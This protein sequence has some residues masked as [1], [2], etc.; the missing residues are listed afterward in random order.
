MKSTG[1]FLTADE[2]ESVK[3]T[4]NTP[5]IAIHT[6][7]PQSPKQRVHAYALAKGLPEIPGYYGA[8]LET[9]EIFEA[10]P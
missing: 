8:S 5:L 6:G 1:K 9:G 2:I 7:M 3:R 4:M 10:T